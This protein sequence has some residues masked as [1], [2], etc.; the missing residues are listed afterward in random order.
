M[1]VFQALLEEAQ[2]QQARQGGGDDGCDGGGAEARGG[3]GG[4]M[5][6]TSGLPAEEDIIH[7]CVRWTIAC[8][9][10]RAVSR[11]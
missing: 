6:D 11:G 5:L 3:G 4:P 10:L 2:E 8:M 9:Q 1:F 7:W